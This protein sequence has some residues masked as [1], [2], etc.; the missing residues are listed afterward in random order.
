MAKATHRMTDRQDQEPAFWLTGLVF[1]HRHPLAP[2][3]SSV[4]PLAEPREPGGH[5]PRNAGMVSAS[6][7]S[8]SPTQPHHIQAVGVAQARRR[9]NTFGACADAS[10]DL[11]R[12]SAARLRRGER[13]VLRPHT[14]VPPW[15]VARHQQFTSATRWR[16]VIGEP[17]KWPTNAGLEQFVRRASSLAD[18]HSHHRSAKVSADRSCVT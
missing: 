7:F 11:G 14:P 3:S 12:C 2:Y 1:M 10:L 8:T 18:V 17:M 5:S 13:H 16:K 15:R 6:S 4:M 9:R